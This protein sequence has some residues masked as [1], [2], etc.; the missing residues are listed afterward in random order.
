MQV[1]RLSFGLQEELKRA[2]NYNT[3]RSETL[4]A[5]GTLGKAANGEE[6]NDFSAMNVEDLNISA[7]QISNLLD[8]F[9]DEIVNIF[10][11]K[12]VEPAQQT[13]GNPD[14]QNADRKPLPL[15]GQAVF[16]A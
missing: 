10:S 8:S 3:A 5:S 6:K 11:G 9:A 13:P 14:T 4:F 15:Q 16:T 1:N 12:F 7:D 2:S